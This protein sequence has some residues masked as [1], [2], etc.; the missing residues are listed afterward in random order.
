MFTKSLIINVNEIDAELEYWLLEA[1][2]RGN[3]F[4]SIQ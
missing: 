4:M 1:Y 3:S 2:I